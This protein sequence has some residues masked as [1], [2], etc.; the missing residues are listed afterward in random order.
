MPPDFKCSSWLHCRRQLSQLLTIKTNFA[1]LLFQLRYREG[2][3]GGAGKARFLVR[4]KRR[5]KLLEEQVRQLF[6]HRRN[7][8]EQHGTAASLEPISV[9][10]AISSNSTTGGGGSGTN[11][12]NNNNNNNNSWGGKRLE[13]LGAPQVGLAEQYAFNDRD[14][15]STNISNGRCFVTSKNLK[16]LKYD[17]VRRAKKVSVLFKRSIW[18]KTYLRICLFLCRVIAA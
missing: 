16:L 7:R 11:N 9:D 2:G 17:A 5:S 10:S 12:N 13:R 15:I 14:E 1:L 8:I 6:E 3:I 18:I 4:N